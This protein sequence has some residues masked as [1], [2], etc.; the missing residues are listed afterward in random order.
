MFTFAVYKSSIV[1]NTHLDK[2]LSYLIFKFQPKKCFSGLNYQLASSTMFMF[3]AKLK[4]IGH[5]RCDDH[6]EESEEQ[7]SVNCNADNYQKSFSQ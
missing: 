2:N 3:R 1:D 4:K 7:L 6:L 5:K